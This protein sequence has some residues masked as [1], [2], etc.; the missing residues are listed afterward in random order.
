MILSR[1]LISHHIQRH[2]TKSTN[3]IYLSAY[4]WRLTFL[5]YQTPFIYCWELA[6]LYC[7]VGKR[8][9]RYSSVILLQFWFL[10]TIIPFV[11]TEPFFF[12]THWD[13]DYPTK[14]C[15]WWRP[16][17]WMAL[18]LGTRD[19]SLKR[20]CQALENLCDEAQ[21]ARHV[22]RSKARLPDVCSTPLQEKLVVPMSL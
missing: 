14:S 1:D 5:I 8:T 3:L 18:A 11:G 4:S 21:D 13:L 2:S 10:L 19:S 22:G 9:S 12:R 17:K 7:I 15:N 20:R 6:F 16:T